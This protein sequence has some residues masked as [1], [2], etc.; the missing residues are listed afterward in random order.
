[1]QTTLSFFLFFLFSS[2]KFP[3]FFYSSAVFG[4]LLVVEIFFL[5]KLGNFCFLCFVYLFKF[6]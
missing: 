5:K 3:N 1:V 4:L 2:S 6:H